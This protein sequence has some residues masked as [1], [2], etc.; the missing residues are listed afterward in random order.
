MT[1]EL[2]VPQ[3]LIWLQHTVATGEEHLHAGA[4]A[5]HADVAAHQLQ[6]GLQER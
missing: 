2:Q 3:Q 6:L 5:W 4:C 1:K